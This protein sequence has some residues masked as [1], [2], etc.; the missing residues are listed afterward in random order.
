MTPEEA[1]RRINEEAIAQGISPTPPLTDEQMRAAF[2]S[3]Q[4][5]AQLVEVSLE[6]A[7]KQI[8]RFQ[9][10]TRELENLRR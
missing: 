7:I 2:A 3:L 8:V 4:N 9:V 5:Y 1:V 6:M 10:M